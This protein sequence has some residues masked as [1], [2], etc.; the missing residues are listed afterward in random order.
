MYKGLEK[1][2]TYE[3][4]GEK[5]QELKYYVDEY[6]WITKS[7][8]PLTDITNQMK[9][10][11]DELDNADI[12]QEDQLRVLKGIHLLQIKYLSV[13]R[14][15]YLAILKRN[16]T[17]TFILIEQYEASLEK[18][19]PWQVIKGV[20]TGNV[21]IKNYLQRKYMISKVN[22]TRAAQSAVN[23]NVEKIEDILGYIEKNYNLVDIKI[24]KD[25]TALMLVEDIDMDNPVQKQ[26]QE[27]TEAFIVNELE[28]LS[29]QI[30]ENDAGLSETEKEKIR[31]KRGKTK[32][33]S[34]TMHL[35]NDS[36]DREI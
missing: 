17:A 33:K 2:K 32:K 15:E 10:L 6:S 11:L 27:K 34:Q 35:E 14:G 25:E 22:D 7:K 13:K 18:H 26:V 12:T 29:D 30:I 3:E 36:K 9:K 16:I 31:E 21:E 1:I 5:K 28:K 19:S 8:E 23:L 4:Y 20:I 24:P